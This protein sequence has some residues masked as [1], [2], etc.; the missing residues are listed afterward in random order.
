M[1]ATGRP[2]FIWTPNG[3]RAA[4]PELSIRV[5]Q[6][7]ARAAAAIRGFSSPF[8]NEGS[9]ARRSV[10]LNAV[11]EPQKVRSSYESLDSESDDGP[12][13]SARGRTLSPRSPDTPVG[14]LD[15]RVLAQGTPAGLAHGLTFGTTNDSLY[16]N[17]SRLPFPLVSLP[18][19]ARIQRYR[20]DRGEEDHTDLPGS[21]AARARSTRSGTF[22][23]MSSRTSPLTPLSPFG[24]LR[25]S[26]TTSTP[27][28]PPTAHQDPFSRR[29]DT[30]SFDTTQSRLHSS[31]LLGGSPATPVPR[32]PSGGP[33]Y[34]VGLRDSPSILGVD[35]RRLRGFSLRTRQRRTGAVG[36]SFEMFSRSETELIR[37]AREDMLL[38]R[39]M[40][41]RENDPEKAIFLVVMVLTLILP[42]IGLIA[43]LGHFDSAISWYTHGEAHCFTK[44][45]RSILKQQLMVEGA[46]YVGLVI[47]LA[48]YFKR[49]N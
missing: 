1:H 23:S 18:D 21:F 27:A 8:S 5:P 35:L 33:W 6:I 31:A 48:V 9:R 15:S 10:P 40:R 39:S 24:D 17:I 34:N 25:E 42:P 32:R 13:P 2:D 7:P 45:Q 43:L 26:V 49:H 38:H 36:Q 4:R 19:A 20:I 22:S 46:L 14:A 30:P 3:I 16:A 47:A 28:R 12:M 41:G 44:E 11:P 29:K 37:S